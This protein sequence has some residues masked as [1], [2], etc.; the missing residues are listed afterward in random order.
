VIAAVDEEAAH[1]SADLG[2]DVRLIARVEHRI[3]VDDQADASFD[4]RRDTDRSDDLLRFLGFLAAQDG[5]A[6]EGADT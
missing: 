1:G 6:E 2:D 5:H 3:R 4:G